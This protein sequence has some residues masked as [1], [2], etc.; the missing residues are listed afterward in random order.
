MGV[1]V[2]E[3]SSG[4]PDEP[5]WLAGLRS[6]QVAARC[7]ARTRRGTACQSP[8]ITDKKRCRIHGGL[9]PGAPHGEQNGNWRH[10]HYGE[11]AQAHRRHLRQ[12]LRD[13]RRLVEDLK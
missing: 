4:Q 9:S 12:L 5:F 3:K 2:T 10:G 11:E 13:M 6:A 8:A 1:G 7:G